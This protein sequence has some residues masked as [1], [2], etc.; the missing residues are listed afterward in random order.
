MAHSERISK[1]KKKILVSMTDQPIRREPGSVDA[2]I[3]SQQQHQADSAA[4]QP[5]TA[6]GFPVTLA[7][8]ATITRPR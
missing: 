8:Q 6:D 7:A 4:L 3:H 1:A 2:F 5:E